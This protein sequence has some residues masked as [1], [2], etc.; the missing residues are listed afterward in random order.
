LSISSLRVVAV[1]GNVGGG[2]GAGGFR[3]GT[4]YPLPLELITPLLLAVV[5]LLEHRC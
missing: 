3:T 2:G 1:V 4:G 5:A